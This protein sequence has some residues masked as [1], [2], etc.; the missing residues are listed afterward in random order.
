MLT[1]YNEILRKGPLTFV[2][3]YIRLR[4][5]YNMITVLLQSNAIRKITDVTIV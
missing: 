4:I 1:L 2:V 3:A 5:S